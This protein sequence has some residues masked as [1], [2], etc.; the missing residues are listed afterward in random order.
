MFTPGSRVCG[1]KTVSGRHEFLNPDPIQEQGGINLYRFVQNSPLSSIDPFGFQDGFANPDNVAALN[2][3]EDMASGGSKLP[4]LSPEETQGAKDAFGN[5]LK[6]SREICDKAVEKLGK[7][8][9][10]KLKQIAQNGLKKAAN[11][12]KNA[13]SD[14]SKDAA[15]KAAE[16]QI[17]RLNAINRALRALK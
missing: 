6:G 5:G 4:K 15:M 14:S 12:L 7:D 8:T 17:N 2:E 9:L 10:G 11:Q 16:T 3:L 13:T 1:Y